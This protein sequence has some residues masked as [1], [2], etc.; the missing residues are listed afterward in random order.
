MSKQSF[1]DKLREAAVDMQAA[2]AM[3]S[4]H[5]EGGDGDMPRSLPEGIEYLKG[6]VDAYLAKQEPQRYSHRNGEMAPPTVEG[7]YWLRQ[8]GLPGDVV[9]VVWQ[10]EIRYRGKVDTRAGWIIVGEIDHYVDELADAQWWG[11]VTP[12]WEHA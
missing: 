6:A 7:F 5:V 4:A 8:E 10:D 11:P 12:P 2:G 9:H 1:E 3:L